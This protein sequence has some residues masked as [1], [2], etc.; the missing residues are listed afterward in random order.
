MTAETFLLFPMLGVMAVV[1]LLI[2]IG[3]WLTPEVWMDR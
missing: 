3:L 2:G 1:V